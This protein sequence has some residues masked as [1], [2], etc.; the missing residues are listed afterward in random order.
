MT[1]EF[2]ARH[3]VDVSGSWE[4]PAEFS[5]GPEQKNRRFH[6]WSIGKYLYFLTAESFS[7]R[8]I[9]TIGAKC[10]RDRFFAGIYGF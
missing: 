10:R 2:F 7:V 9:V 4:T 5:I 6:S 3:F 8:Q 1:V